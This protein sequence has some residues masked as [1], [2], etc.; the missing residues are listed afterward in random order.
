MVC[1]LR[2][3]PYQVDQICLVVVTAQSVDVQRV[4]IVPVQMIPKAKTLITGWG[5]ERAHN[6]NVITG[7]TIYCWP[8]ISTISCTK[9]SN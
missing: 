1:S 8:D 5:D 9:M 6:A 7:A 4:D 2:S 3:T